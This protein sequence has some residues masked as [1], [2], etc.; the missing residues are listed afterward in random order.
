MRI[1]FTTTEMID[2]I[3]EQ[4]CDGGLARYLCKITV[5]LKNEGHDVNVIV[6]ND[7]IEK[8]VYYYGVRVFFVRY[9]NKYSI[10]NRLLWHTLSKK[11]RHNIM[12]DYIHR[13]IQEEHSK[14]TIDIIQYASYKGLGS[15]PEGDIPSCVRISSYAKLWQKSYNYCNKNEIE[16]EVQQFKK[17]KYLYGPSEYIANYIK[18][19]LNL[20][21]EIRIIETPFVPSNVQDDTELYDQLKEKIGEHPYLIFFGSLGLLK[22]SQEIAEIVDETFRKYP[23]LFIV[24]VGKEML[25]AG[26]SPVEII[27]Y[28][29]K[30]N[31]D[32]VIYFP[33]T[34]HSKLF[35]LV[36]G[37]K[38]VM[39]PSRIDNLPNTCIE[40]MGLGK[41]VIGSRGAS[42]EQLIND[43]INGFLCDAGDAR[44]LQDAIDRLMESSD[45]KLKEISIAATQRSKTMYLEKIVPKVVRYYEEVIKGWNNN[46]L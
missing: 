34:S 28:H 9:R 36:K 46:N 45:E 5:A 26:K 4:P 29:A 18:T 38:A 3:T 16:N 13:K 12:I 21:K 8:D 1:F 11:K 32:R 10:I 41:V 2:P 35:P 25:V 31:S 42:F 30:E 14:K 6:I 22:G 27:K 40:S 20:D 7:A 44:S 15:Q 43:G 24:L 17:A 33:K 23:E 37:A 39:L 19:D